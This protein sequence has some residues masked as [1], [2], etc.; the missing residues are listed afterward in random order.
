MDHSADMIAPRP[1][2]RSLLAGALCAVAGSACATVAPVGTPGLKTVDTGDG[3][4][5][6]EA[7][8][9][10]DGAAD[11]ADGGGDGGGGDGGAG[12][13]DTG[14]PGPAPCGELVP[15]PE[16]PFLPPGVDVAAERARC[17]EVWHALAGPRGATL[18]LTLVDAAGAAWPGPARVTLTD[19]LGAP[20][21]GPVELSAGGAVDVGLVQSGEVFARLAPVDPDA[22]GH[23]YTLRADCVAGCELAYTRYPVVLMHGMAGDD[24][25][26]G[27][28]DYF[29]GVEAALDERGYLAIAPGVDAFGPVEVRAAQW[30]AHLN[31]LEAAG[32]GRRFNLI[33]HSQGGLDGRYLAGALG[34]DRVVS[35]I[36][37][38]TPHRGTAL[39]DAAAGVI[40]LTPLG[41]WA[42]DA[43]LDL[44][45]QL[46]G[47]GDAALVDQIDDLS[48]AN[49]EAFNATVPDPPG[50]YLA[51]WAGKTCARLD[52]G[53]RRDTDD[54]VAS[55]WFALT[56]VIL[57]WVEGD[58]D[59]LVS[60]E[61]ATWADF[62]GVL[63]ADH[64]DETGLS[65]PLATAPL[66][67][68]AFYADEAAR[69]AAMGL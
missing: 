9:G 65:D 29:V 59:G 3:A 26:L 47:L 36:T 21:A 12:G 53:C 22:D 37:V 32:V 45:T 49:A 48:T 20:V 56:T 57:G 19:L 34:D 43:A 16:G 2:L 50:V 41:G 64:L 63:P 38:S 44:L 28:L 14:D 33:A 5:G 10:A 67:H 61:S 35:L 39:A 40:D 23:V 54:E 66:D 52:F 4:D 1:L 58:N 13:A 55:S 30:Q 51:S 7:G 6:D 60:V 31:D 62:R 42:L 18:R 25:W 17:A 46:T 69:L 8:G 24:A 15:A 27:V 68:R 11:G